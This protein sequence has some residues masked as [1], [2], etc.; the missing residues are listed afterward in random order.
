[1]KNRKKLLGIL[2]AVILG[3]ASVVGSGVVAFGTM[4]VQN[5]YAAEDVASGMFQGMDWR[6]TSE[7][8]LELGNVGITQTLTRA[9]SQTWPW[10]VNAGDIISVRCVGDIKAQG[11]LREMFYDC[12]NLSD[13]DL[14]R[15][16]TSE[17]TDMLGMFKRCY[18]LT[19]LDL[20]GFNTAQVTNMGQMFY[21]TLNLESID[22]SSFDT[23]NVTN[24]QFM[25]ARCHV[26]TLNVSNFNTENCINMGYM[27]QGYGGTYLD[28]SNFD[29]GNVN[30]MFAMFSRCLNL[31]SLKLDDKF[32]MSKVTQCNAMFE[33]C[34]NLQYV[35]V[36]PAIK[37]PP[38]FDGNNMN[39]GIF[40][41]IFGESSGIGSSGWDDLHQLQKYLCELVAKSYYWNSDDSITIVSVKDE[42]MDTASEATEKINAIADAFSE[43]QLT[44]EKFSIIQENLI[45]LKS[46]L[47]VKDVIPT[48]SKRLLQ[49]GTDTISDMTF[50]FQFEQQS[51]WDGVS[52]VSTDASTAAPIADKSVTITSESEVLTSDEYVGDL[53]GKKLYQGKVENVLSDFAPK[54]A[55]TYCYLVKEDDSNPIPDVTY[56]GSQFIMLV[57]VEDTGNGVYKP[58]TVTNI[59]YKDSAGKTKADY[60][61]PPAVFDE[62]QD[63]IFYNTYG[64]GGGTT[65]TGIMTN[66]LPYIVIGGVGV[67]GLAL[68][69]ML[70]VRRRR[71]I[72]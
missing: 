61:I 23:S 13:V 46:G 60:T 11:S 70:K 65:P 47:R 63:L 58:T 51:E 49:N 35:D 38:V 12:Q 18:N 16:D 52:Y 71:K 67:G 4:L 44:N 3:G 53:T 37:K 39:S 14:K 33:G 7:G 34:Y 8:V 66:I 25:F 69:V 27:F 55:G 29:T 59:L 36:I 15:L 28:I 56:T 43:N 62:K 54:A 40:Y 50:N 9:S 22:I 20:S 45:F 26:K 30:N 41:D 19:S 6:I 68:Y 21:D 48:I 2:S 64:T 5:V 57:E 1:M 24:M 31:E 17:V 32:D 42:Y 72:S 10:R